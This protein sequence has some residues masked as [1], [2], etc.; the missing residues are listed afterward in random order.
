MLIMFAYL[1]IIRPL[2]GIVSLIAVWIGAL[3]AGGPFAPS[4][5]IILGMISVFLISGGGM[6]IN[7]F[8]DVEI[9]KLNRPNR[10]IPL[11]KITK[12]SA[13]GYASILF[14]AGIAASYFI[15]LDTLVI[16]IIAAGLLIAYAAML[17]KTVLI[18]NL[19]ISGLVALTFVFGGVIIGNYIAILPL[20]L[21][22]FLSNVGREIYKTIDDA[23]GDKKYEV[24]S[25][26]I[27]LGVKSARII[28]NIF[29]IVAI[30]FSFVPYFLGILGA[31][32]LFFVVIADIVF[33]VSTAAPLKYSSKLALI[34]IVIGVFAFLAGVYNA[35][36]ISVVVS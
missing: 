6:A 23:L 20:A 18:G 25:V 32:Y 36:S 13:L 3:I 31:T 24:N 28:A 22:A 4:I 5:D 21:L 14:V 15:N 34:G 19:V 17:K 1:K 33:L 16:A 11:G 2:N 26:A 29:L 8:F 27:K 12:R 9:D 10:P 7:D 35:Q 30:I